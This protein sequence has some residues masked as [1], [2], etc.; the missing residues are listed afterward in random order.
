MYLLAVIVLIGMLPIERLVRRALALGEKVDMR[1]ARFI[2][3]RQ[4]LDY[5][6][7]ITVRVVKS[8]DNRTTDDI[9]F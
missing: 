5:G 2:T 7:D 6:E 3:I 8:R 1:Q 4:E 9:P